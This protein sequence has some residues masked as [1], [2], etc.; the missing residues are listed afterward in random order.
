M[1]IKEF[2]GSSLKVGDNVDPNLAKYYE[3][4]KFPEFFSIITFERR[5][6]TK[7]TLNK[8]LIKPGRSQG[9][10]TRQINQAI[11]FLFG[12][13]KVKIRDHWKDGNE[14]KAN[15][16][17]LSRIENRLYHAHYISKCHIYINYRELII[18]ISDQMIN[19]VN[20]CMKL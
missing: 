10:S 4:E 9:N 6:E 20:E 7:S 15:E 2:P 19:N 17:L 1:L 13:Y 5:A 3:A 12:G 14:R 11:E 8:F 18:M 16:M